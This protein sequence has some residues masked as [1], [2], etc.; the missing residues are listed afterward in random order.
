MKNY[1]LILKKFFK[2]KKNKQ[3]YSIHELN[4]HR[5]REKKIKLARKSRAYIT[6]LNKKQRLWLEKINSKT[7]QVS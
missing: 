3:I 6:N 1:F 2:S 4:L 5:Q 7:R